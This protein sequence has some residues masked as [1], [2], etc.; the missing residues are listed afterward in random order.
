MSNSSLKYFISAPQHTVERERL[1]H[2]TVAQQ[3]KLYAAKSGV[4]LMITEPELDIEGFDFVISSEFE[5]I[6]IQSKGR[7]KQGGAKQ[8]KIR[9]A[10][11]KPS[12]YNSDLVPELDGYKIGG[13]A[14][15]ASG[16]VLIHE[17]DEGGAD[18]GEFNVSYYYL[19]IFWLIGVASGVAGRPQLQRKRAVELLR[20][21]R[22]ADDV[23]RVTIHLKDFARLKSIA[24]LAYLRLHVSG[25][26]NWASSCYARGDLAELGCAGDFAIFWQG[27]RDVLE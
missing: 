2:L 9:A 10:L 1:L 21:I 6:Y 4:R 24:S 26:S 16:G 18:A 20:K 13:Y 11:L 3:L 12:L 7:L 27:V 22:A 8:W 19:D 23:Q 5:S 15:G 14:T 17:I 25:P